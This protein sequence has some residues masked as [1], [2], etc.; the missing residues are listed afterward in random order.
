M[1]LTM[2]TFDTPHMGHAIFL[3]RC[4][5]I[6]GEGRVLVGLN[7]DEF[8]AGYKGRVPFYGYDERRTMIEQFGFETTPNDGPGR[9]LLL[10]TRPRIL[11]V[12][13]DWAGRDYHAQIDTTAADL[14]DWGILLA[15][16]GYRRIV[17]TSDL[18]RRLGSR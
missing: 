7:T 18:I 15:Y 17:S 16:V 2:G 11:A 13:D 5:I 4:R 9:D 6:A 3:D 10:Q 12:G 1:L 14:D 8:V